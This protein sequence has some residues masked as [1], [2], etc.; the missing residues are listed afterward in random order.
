MIFMNNLVDFALRE[1]YYKV[2]KLRSKLSEMNALL[3]WN[4]FAVLFPEKETNRGAPGYDV[5]LKI[6]C[7]FLQSWY[8]ISDEELEFQ[9]NDRFSFQ[10]FLGFPSKVPDYSTIWRFKEYLQEAN[11]TDVIWDELQRQINSHNIKVEE[12]SIQDARFVDAQ[13]GKQ[14]SDKINRGR[15]A[16]T[17]RNKDGT[18]TKKYGK[19]H[20]GYKLHTKV[21]RGSKII[22]MIA[23][24]TAK[25]HDSNLD[26][27][28]ADDKVIYRDRAWTG[29]P[30]KAKG[31][32]SMKR[33]KLLNIHE[34]LRNKRI[35]KK[36]AIVEHPYATMKR[37][38]NAG[39]I[40]KTTIPR[41]FVQQLFVCMAYNLHRLRFLVNG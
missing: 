30:T 11:L 34:K 21:K 7:L 32:G 31:N 2:R 18:W 38:F 4:A 13:P 19:S 5:V 10:E 23:V 26:L 39:T 14:S 16:K 6:K 33:G 37:S 28:T 3:D 9:I 15:Q 12:G 24:T 25:V 8:N 41:V 1:K 35:S 27:G 29:I 40:K 17:S 20:F 36:R 22:T